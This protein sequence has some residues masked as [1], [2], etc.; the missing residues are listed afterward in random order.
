M[1]TEETG[2]DG[3]EA[4]EWRRV[5]EGLRSAV[6]DKVVSAGGSGEE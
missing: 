5:G 3:G 4:G 1:N 2:E 6:G